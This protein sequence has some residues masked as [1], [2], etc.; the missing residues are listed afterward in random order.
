MVQ[1]TRIFILALAMAG[2]PALN[3]FAQ[4]A[5]SLPRP[6]NIIIMIA[7]GAGYNHIKAVEYYEGMKAQVY[8]QFPVHLAMVI[9]PYWLGKIPP[10]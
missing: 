5:N 1:A 2:L 8:Q 9:I 10:T 4:P 3:M 6:K 7:D